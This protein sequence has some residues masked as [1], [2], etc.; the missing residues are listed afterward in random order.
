[1]ALATV[2]WVMSNKLECLDLT[3]QQHVQIPEK[4]EKQIQQHVQDDDDHHIYSYNNYHKCDDEGVPLNSNEIDHEMT[5][6]MHGVESTYL[7]LQSMNILYKMIVIN[8]LVTLF[9]SLHIFFVL[10]AVFFCFKVKC[11]VIL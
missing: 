1:M 7:Y 10:Y 3:K 6:F 4:L 11:K 8:K 2:A 5:D 9:A